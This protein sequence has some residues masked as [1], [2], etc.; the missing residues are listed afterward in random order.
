MMQENSKNIIEE[1]YK[2][3]TSINEAVDPAEREEFR[4]RVANNPTN[5]K[6]Q[7][8]AKKYGYEAGQ[9]YI[10]SW[11][12]ANIRIMRKKDFSPEIYYTDSSS[13]KMEFKIQTTSYGALNEK[14]YETFLDGCQD[15]YNLVKEL[16]KVDLSKLEKEPTWNK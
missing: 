6:I 2:S 1:L 13:G 12:D 16:G 4:K 3:R 10:Y 7:S 8:I 11:G 15:A 14:Q 5:K 9:S